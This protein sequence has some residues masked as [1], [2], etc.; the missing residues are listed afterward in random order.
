MRTR[1]NRGRLLKHVGLSGLIMWFVTLGLSSEFIEGRVDN[2][3]LGNLRPPVVNVQDQGAVGDG[4]TDDTAKIQKT[5]DSLRESGGTVFFPPGTYRISQITPNKSWSLLLRPNIDYVGVGRSST[6]LLAPGQ[7]GDRQSFLRMMATEG[8]EISRNI[9]I[10]YLEFNGNRHQQPPAICRTCD[11]CPPECN[12]E[13]MHGVFLANVQDSRVEHCEFHGIAGDAVYVFQGPDTGSTNVLVQNNEMYD[14]GRVGVNFAGTSDSIAR[15]NFIHDTTNNAMKMETE[16]GDPPESGNWFVGNE[17][18]SAGGIALG[19]GAPVS[20]IFITDNRFENTP[21]EAIRLSEVSNVKVLR[22]TIVQST[23]GAITVLSSLDVTIGD[24]E[25]RDTLLAGESTNERFNAVILVHS[26]QPEC[27]YDPDPKRPLLRTPSIGII[28]E[29]NTIR[30]NALPGIKFECSTYGVIQNN[31]ILNNGDLSLGEHFGSGIY[32][33]SRETKNTLVADNTIENNK[34][35]GILVESNAQYNRF[36]RNKIVNNSLGGIRI[37]ATAGVGN[38][39]GTSVEPGLNCIHDNPTFGLLNAAFFID[40][41]GVKHPVTVFARGNFWGCEE[42]PRDPRNTACN[43]VIEEERP[44][45]C[46]EEEQLP[47]CAVRTVEVSPILCEC[48]SVPEPGCLIE[49]D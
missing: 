18:R 41:K 20:D 3:E 16:V 10:R 35:F 23:G 15:F 44:P 46:I 21:G 5:I 48:T 28:I 31:S 7:V 37:D 12:L 45:E 11:S 43:R 24:N 6:L 29:G 14:L 8:S 34:S 32:L 30:D 9:T 25:I 26:N 47:E 17:I 13:Q 27:V 2:P 40:T 1:M 19:G 42:D 49:V 22:N 4:V 39:F 36:Q 33:R 38:E